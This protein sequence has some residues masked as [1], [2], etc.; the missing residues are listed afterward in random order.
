MSLNETTNTFEP[1]KVT[2]WYKNNHPSKQWYKVEFNC[3]VDPTQAKTNSRWGT[4]NG[5]VFT[6]DHRMLTNNGYV[7]IA[8]IDPSVHKMV[9]NE[10]AISDDGMQV[11]L[12]S[13]LADGTLQSK[14]G[15]GAGIYLSQSKNHR[16]NF[17]FKVASLGGIEGF[18]KETAPKTSNQNGNL[19]F[20]SNYTKQFSDMYHELPTRDISKSYKLVF[21]KDLAAKLDAR[22]LACWYMDDGN[23][24][25]I[26]AYPRIW[27]T[28]SS[29]EER[30]LMLDWLADLGWMLHSMNR[31]ITH[32][33][34]F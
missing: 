23:L 4:L 25:S 19:N 14:N 5:P 18:Y 29:A 26:G 8:K 33:F 7:E 31:V 10:L 32:L 34:K 30:E 24:P 13:L 21:T 1:K 16:S 9:S 20:Y 17:E 3:G 11:V 2:G 22:A 28:T 27:T 12:A 6:P 15:V